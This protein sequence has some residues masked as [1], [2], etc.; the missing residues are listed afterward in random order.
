[1]DG[2]SR[3]DEI[4]GTPLL[5]RKCALA[6]ANAGTGVLQWDWTR[7]ESYGLLRRDGSH[8]QWMDIISGI[9]AFAH[10][11]QAYTPESISP[12]NSI[13]SAAIAPALFIRKLGNY[14]ATKCCTRT[15]PLCEGDS[16]CHR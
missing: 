2:L 9:A 5:E 7:S 4:Q 3:W 12:E 11:A 15:L 16:I 10:D 6:F 8:K 14:S 1:M 13:G